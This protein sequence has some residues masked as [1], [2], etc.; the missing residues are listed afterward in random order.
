MQW[1]VG[2]DTTNTSI[3]RVDVTAWRLQGPRSSRVWG[4]EQGDKDKG[5]PFPHCQT[6]SIISLF[7]MAFG[8]AY[9]NA[10]KGL[11]SLARDH[12]PP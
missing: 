2:V 11:N 8:G 7:F 6:K 12:L 5:M 4:R 9:E 1:S 10:G 3:A